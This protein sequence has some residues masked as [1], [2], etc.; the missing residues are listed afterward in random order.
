[1]VFC[2]K[3]GTQIPSGGVFCPKCGTKC[4]VSENR[5]K[6]PPPKTKTPMATTTP[7][8]RA[9]SP[10][11]SS[12]TYDNNPSPINLN[13]TTPNVKSITTGNAQGAKST[14]YCKKK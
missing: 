7:I 1:M 12:R 14:T 9:K 6:S 3:C 5:S 2:S 13:R 4:G 11:P 10:T 8:N